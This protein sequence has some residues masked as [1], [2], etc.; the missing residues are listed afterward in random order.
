MQPLQ[1]SPAF[2][3]ID[4]ASGGTLSVPML[5]GS[6]STAWTDV[7]RT[8]R[9]QYADKWDRNFDYV[10]FYHFG[11]RTNPVP[12]HL[13]PVVEGSFFTFCSNEPGRPSGVRP[14]R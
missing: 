4:V 10:I 8:P 2:A 9:F 1:A 11:A 14:A 13:T 7:E 12:Q 3:C 6:V 5:R